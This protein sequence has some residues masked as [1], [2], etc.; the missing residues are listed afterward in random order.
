VFDEATREYRE[1]AVDSV[2]ADSFPASD[3]PS[4]TLGVPQSQPEA[5]ASEEAEV[6]ADDEC[7][8]IK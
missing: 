5:A 3:P 6:P 7:R 2:L 1:R 8:V 4:W